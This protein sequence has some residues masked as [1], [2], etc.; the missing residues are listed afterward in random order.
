MGRPA[1]HKT[2]EA[3][4]LAVHR[5]RARYEQSEKGKRTRQKYALKNIVAKYREWRSTEVPPYPPRFSPMRPS[6]FPWS[7]RSSRIPARHLIATRSIH[8]PFANLDE[9]EI[10]L[11]G[12]MT[13]IEEDDEERMRERLKAKGAK[14]VSQLWTSESFGLKAYWENMKR[15]ERMAGDDVDEVEK[16]MFVLHRRW[17]A[18]D[19]S[20]RALA[21][22]LRLRLGQRMIAMHSSTYYCG[23]TGG[24]DEASRLVVAYVVQS[25]HPITAVGN[26]C[27]KNPYAARAASLLTASN[28]YIASSTGTAPTS[29]ERPSRPLASEF[30]SATHPENPA[31]LPI[32]LIRISPSYTPTAFILSPWIS[33]P[34]TAAGTPITYSCSDGAGSQLRPINHLSSAPGRGHEPG[35]VNATSSGELTVR[36]PACPRPG[37]NLPDNWQTASS[38]DQC[39][40]T[41]FIAVD[42]CFRLKRGMVS[43][44]A[45]DPPLSDGWGYMVE[46][47]PYREYLLT[48]K[49]QKEISSCTDLAA[50][51]HAN[52]KFAKGYTTTGVGMAVC[53]RHEYG[54][55]DYIVASALRHISRLLRLVV[56]YD[57]A[58]QWWKGLRER[59]QHLP[60]LVRLSLVLAMVRFV[61]PKLHIKGHT[62]ACQLLYSLHLTLGCGQ[63]DGE[64]IERLW[65]AINALAGSTK[66]NGPGARS[67]QL[68][69]HWGFSNWAKLVGLP[70]L[71]R[72]RV[73]A[74]RKEAVEHA[75][76]WLNM[77]TVFEAPR[78]DGAPEPRNP[79]EATVTG[80]TEKQV[81]AEFEEEDKKD[82]AAGVPRIHGTSPRSF[83]MFG[84][85]I[86]ELQSRIR[87]QAALKKA[88]STASKINLGT[89][90][91]KAELMIRKWRSLQ[92][93]YMPAA[94]I[95]LKELNLPPDI[96]VENIPLLLPSTLTPK[97]RNDGCHGGIEE[98][99]VALRQPQCR[100][101]LVLIRNQ[102]HIKARL[103]K[104]K[105]FSSRHQATNTRTRTLVN[106]NESKLK[107]HAEKYQRAWRALSVLPGAR[108]LVSPCYELPTSV[109]WKIPSRSP[110]TC[111]RKVRR[112]KRRAELIAQGDLPL[113]NTSEERIRDG[114]EE[115][116]GEDMFLGDESGTT[117][118]EGRRTMSWIWNETGTTGSEEE[119]L[120]ALRIEWCK[121]FSRMRRWK[122]E[123]VARSKWVRDSN[124][125]P[126][127]PA[128]A[129]LLDGKVAYAAK[130]RDLYL[131]LMRRAEEVRTA[132]EGKRRRRKPANAAEAAGFDQHPDLPDPVSDSSDDED[133]EHGDGE[134]PLE[135]GD[136][137]DI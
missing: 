76:E 80:K 90:R 40:Y 108:S 50:L 69:D 44:N 17:L 32:P 73:D 67:D 130:Q 93:T 99:E 100:V 107:L 15:A 23:T 55:M 70:A 111:S 18:R 105:K 97:E 39:L 29:S 54:N 1:L 124:P 41:Q 35:G 25:A 72:R 87:V 132:P 38:R 37:I 64:G 49:D 96:L 122:E 126:L 135:E 63:T 94:L 78:A 19:S 26:A 91:R 43:S 118:G 88:K 115:A 27:I 30:S 52:T 83:I 28:H 57:I 33:V 65:A 36:C 66:L 103:M 104:Y 125:G 102:L 11:H 20:A 119:L 98:I 113:I 21:M 101:A 85:E 74:A 6:L 114:G 48:I 58:C 51:D 13:R 16:R 136:A 134:E 47:R 128:Q 120:D 133:D 46:G 116:D 4:A 22:T 8:R 31:L 79:Y 106:R 34:A 24:G 62:L 2:P 89:M 9:L 68:D 81:R 95:R 77:V 84:L 117:S 3:K 109:A 59:L 121:A 75:P 137:E 131:T 12:Y 42:A 86:E 129:E 71:L 60:P 53:A 92:A 45:K 112:M 10:R 127:L 110:P 7:I 123:W 61:V 5:T 14:F 82:A 56:S